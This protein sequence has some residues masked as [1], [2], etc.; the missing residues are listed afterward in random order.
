MKETRK[1]KGASATALPTPLFSSMIRQGKPP[2]ASW[3]LV[4]CRCSSCVMTA[5][6]PEEHCVRSTADRVQRAVERRIDTLLSFR[7]LRESVDG[8]ITQLS[9]ISGQAWRS[10]IS[11]GF[12]ALYPPALSET[13]RRCGH[14]RIWHVVESNSINYISFLVLSN[15]SSARTKSMTAIKINRKFVVMMSPGKETVELYVYV[16]FFNL[17][18]KILRPTSIAS[19]TFQSI[20]IPPNFNFQLNGVRSSLSALAAAQARPRPACAR[21]RRASAA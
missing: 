9:S 8:K 15:L 18:A 14:A 19:L 13:F 11:I 17:A 20:Y 3:V 21:R 7:Y 10:P 1:D 2:H 6:T 16:D 4:R 5:G 12:D